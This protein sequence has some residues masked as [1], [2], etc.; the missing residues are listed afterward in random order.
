MEE[1]LRR[2]N[3]VVDKISEDVTELLVSDG[4]KHERIKSLEYSRKWA[5]IILGTVI[6]AIII[7]VLI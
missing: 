6:A 4:R 1:T 2:I 7:G 3:K 5:S